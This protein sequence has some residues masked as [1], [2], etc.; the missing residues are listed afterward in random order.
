MGVWG[1]YIWFY[2]IGELNVRETGVEDEV[3][4]MSKRWS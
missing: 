4:K 1:N 2:L 3:G